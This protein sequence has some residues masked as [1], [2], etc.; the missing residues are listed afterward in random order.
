MSKQV[1]AVLA[2]L[3]AMGALAKHQQ[4]EIRRYLNMKS[5]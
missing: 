5:M 1:M 3:I 4:P 2:V